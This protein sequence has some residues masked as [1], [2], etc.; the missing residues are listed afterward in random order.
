MG[1]ENIYSTY[2]VHIGGN[3]KDTM[4]P[5]NIYSTYIVHIGG[6]VKD[7]LGPEN[8]YSTFDPKQNEFVC[9]VGAWK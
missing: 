9:I 8:I 7:T 2:I 6:N 4:G 3:I 5:E 1:P